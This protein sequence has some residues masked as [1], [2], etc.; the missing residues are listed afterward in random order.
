MKKELPLWMRIGIGGVA[1]AVALTGSAPARVA[2][3]VE[4]GGNVNACT[5]FYRYA[6]NSICVPHCE[7]VVEIDGTYNLKITGVTRLENGVYY[8][9]VFDCDGPCVQPTAGWT[10]FPAGTKIEMAT[11][12][13]NRAQR[14]EHGGQST[15]FGEARK[16]IEEV[17][18]GDRVVSQDERGEK[19]VSVVTKLDQPVRDHM[20][21]VNFTD[22][23]EIKLTSEHPLFSD[24][25]WKAIDPKK[26]FEEI[27]SLPVTELKRGD[28][29]VK[30]DDSRVEVKSFACWSETIQTYNLILDGKVNT[31]FAGGLLA[32]N[33]YSYKQCPAGEIKSCGTE[34]NAIDQNKHKCVSN[35]KACDVN[36]FASTGSVESCAT[37]KKPAKKYC[38]WNCTCCP[39]GYHR[40]CTVGV[41]YTAD[42]DINI[43]ANTPEQNIRDRSTCPTNIHDEIWL[44]GTIVSTYVDYKPPA[45]DENDEE[46]VVWK[47]SC[48]QN[49]CGCVPDDPPSCSLTFAPSSPQCVS[50]AV[51]IYPNATDDVGVST[52][53]TY[54][55]T[56]IGGSDPPDG[57]DLIG[58]SSSGNVSWT[59]GNTSHIGGTHVVAANVWDAAQK[60]YQCRANYQLLPTVNG[61]N[62]SC[63]S[64]N[65]VATCDNST[66]SCSIGTFSWTDSTGSDGVFN[67]GCSGT[68]GE[69]GG[70]S[71][72]A[73]TCSAP[74]LPDV[75]G[76]CGSSHGGDFISAP[77]SNLCDSGTLDWIDHRGSDGKFNWQCWGSCAGVTASCSA[78]RNF[79]PAFTSLTIKNNSGTVVVA[80]AGNKNQ[81]C[82]T[83]FGGSRNVIF[84]VRAS[85]PDRVA[86]ISNITMTLNGITILRTSSIGTV[87]TF[88]GNMDS[89]NDSLAYPLVVT[90]TDSLG[91]V[92]T[93]NSRSFK[94]WDC[95]VPISGTIFDDSAQLGCSGGFVTPADVSMGFSSINYKNMSGGAD[96]VGT[97]NPPSNFG[98]DNLIWGKSYLPLINGGSVANIDGDLAALGRT[99]KLNSVCPASTQFTVNVDAYA[100]S[101]NLTLDL[102]YIRDQENWFQGNG[103]D[104]RAGIKITEGVPVTATNPY[105][106]LNGGLVEAPILENTNG[107]NN[108]WHYGTPPNNWFLLA[109][110]ID[111]H[112]YSYQS[113]YNEYFTKMGEGVTGVTVINVGSTG[114]LF[115]NVGLTISSDVV[116]AANKYLMVVVNGNMTIDQSVNNVD[117]IY[118]AKNISEGGSSNT[119]LKINGML[120]ATK[121]GNIRLNR[122]FTTKSDNNTTPA[123]VVNYRPDMIL[124]VHEKLNKILAGW[125]EL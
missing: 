81:I 67:W 86:D 87:T 33:K 125:R 5:S 76:V 66:A 49:S 94:V 18:V 44:G 50:T 120:Y 100:T 124:A 101:Q 47:M 103:L 2:Q 10:C 117:G 36:Y 1:G 13:D 115:V 38:N 39:T 37:E 55:N 80:E 83:A 69:C 73:V 91:Q 9:E 26:T 123:V 79:P 71:G 23:S 30:F 40:G 7:E 43:T 56:N 21:K 84:E 34:Q 46:H 42:K 92:A 27:P 17:R 98:S 62:G 64:G 114:V 105:L 16:N 68:T 104:M 12:N 20:C 45:G 111:P 93:N 15:D 11:G 24:T 8:C 119:Q 109:S 110:G 77:S 35:G 3:I 75:S 22:G 96:V 6:P 89:F 85:D 60:F 116:V 113:I 54:V 59:T 72:S 112:K 97:A 121:G 28:K 25:G 58:E 106:I 53:M 29:I 31:Y 52:V 102:S 61:I 57:W 48:I 82:Q 95:N 70:T 107:Y 78:T 4:G 51:N 65:G 90:I 32:H 99:T 108:N 14:T 19:S 63:G 118:V 74:H 41:G 88:G 122:S